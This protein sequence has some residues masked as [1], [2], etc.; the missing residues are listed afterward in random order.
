MATSYSNSGGT[1]DRISLITI[2]TT[3]S[4]G[5]GSNIDRLIDGTKTVNNTSAACWWIA[6]QSGR[7]IVFDYTP[8]GFKQIID[9]FTWTQQFGATQG[10]WS[11][12]GWNGSSYVDLLTGITLG[13]GGAVIA[14]SFSNTND[15]VKYRLLQTSGVTDDNPWLQEWEAKIEQGASISSSIT[16]TFALTE[17]SDVAAFTGQIDT[18]GFFALFEASDVA[19]FTGELPITGTLAITES[20]DVVSFIGTSP[21]SGSLAAIESTDLASFQAKYV[22]HPAVIALVLNN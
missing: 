13:T 5:G 16:G 14:Y 6:G 18:N 4:L 10:T 7:E 21:Y 15:Y 9:E 11:F 8:S 1:G 17:D 2:T 19:A 20:R 3:A 22:K 12:Q